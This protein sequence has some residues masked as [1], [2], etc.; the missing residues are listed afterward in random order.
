MKVGIEVRKNGWLRLRWTWQCQT[1]TLS[2]GIADNRP[3]RAIAESIAA[4]IR[5]D[6]ANQIY[7]HASYKKTY[8]LKIF[9]NNATVI[10]CLE[11]FD[12]YLGTVVNGLSKGALTRYGSVRSW[13]GKLLPMGCDRLDLPSAGNFLARLQETVSNNTAKSYL[14]ILK[15]CWDW[16]EASFD[17][18]KPNP[19]AILLPK[20]K[21][22]KT[23]AIEPFTPEEIKAILQGF[24]QH[25]QY[26]HYGDFV[27]FLANTGVRPGEAI[28]LVWADLS[29]DF[30]H[31]KISKSFS[32][33]ELRLS[34]KTGKSRQMHLSSGVA[35][36]LRDRSQL[37]KS[38]PTDIV[39]AAP[40]GGYINIQLFGRRAWKSVLESAGVKY[41]NVYTLRHTVA[42]IALSDGGKPV[43]IAAQMGHSTR[44]LLDTYG[45]SVE[46][47]SPF[48][49][50]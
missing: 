6:F 18:V 44:M 25:P 8:G 1:V 43:E 26:C 39:F 47:K 49:E 28:A 32:C 29:P 40:K 30:A 14:W 2:L 3:N 38:E 21:G 33:G 5:K 19:W 10:S 24:Y 23:K 11:L 15:S 46:E 45:H 7:D 37:Q 9:G 42:S 20:V 35:A 16:A 31:A 22:N 13:V 4:R 36:M 34:T 12:R 17:V 41:R 27:R 50:F 48:K